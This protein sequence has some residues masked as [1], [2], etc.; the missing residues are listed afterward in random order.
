MTFLGIKRVIISMAFFCGICHIAG[1]GDINCNI[2]KNILDTPNETYIVP[3]FCETNYEIRANGITLE[4]NGSHT[5]KIHVTSSAGMIT[6]ENL[7]LDQGD[8]SGARIL[9]DN[10][11]GASWDA[12]V[13]IINC[14]ISGGEYS[15][16]NKRANGYVN[17]W[18]GWFRGTTSHVIYNQDG[19]F[20]F[21]FNSIE[22]SGGDGFNEIFNN[23]GS[24]LVH[25]K[26]QTSTYDGLEFGGLD[27]PY[28]Y[29][30]R[31]ENNNKGIKWWY[32]Q[33]GYVAMNDFNP[34]TNGNIDR[35]YYGN[36][37]WTDNDQNHTF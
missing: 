33:D 37:Y 16:R 35:D 23:G 31:I 19:N 15:I 28:I 20:Y 34:N 14:A 7:Y 27:Y 12:D 11:S 32:N 10:Y 21:T 17:V 13:W 25:N 18:D 5:G 2:Y 29:W 24:Y 26:V 8:K 36:S 30:N 6:I 22:W 4:G 1:A 9:I 3:S